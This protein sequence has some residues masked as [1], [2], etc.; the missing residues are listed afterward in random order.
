[1]ILQKK[2]TSNTN[3]VSK[4]GL[5]FLELFQ[6]FCDQNLLK[7]NSLLKSCLNDL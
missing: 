5:I 6:I 7:K 4:K 2:M 1:M 3:R